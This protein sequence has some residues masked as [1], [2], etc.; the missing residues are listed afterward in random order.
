MCR[1]GAWAELTVEVTSGDDVQSRMLGFKKDLLESNQDGRPCFVG[2]DA[3]GCGFFIMLTKYHAKCKMNPEKV[4][5][6]QR[7]CFLLVRKIDG[8]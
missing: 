4:R 3:A 2:K 8:K 1:E 7:G 5:P 6:M